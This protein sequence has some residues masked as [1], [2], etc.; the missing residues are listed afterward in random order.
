MDVHVPLAVTDSL[1]R[2]GIDVLTSQ[3]DKTTK[4]DDQRLLL[5]AAELRRVLFSQDMDFLELG[6]E[7]QRTNVPFSGIVYAHQLGLGIGALI[8]E[9]RLIASCAEPSE[10]ANCVL[11][12]PLR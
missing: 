10:L 7:F 8:D 6:A 12:L 9:L 4:H 5:R 11:F 2:Q 1:R 3:R